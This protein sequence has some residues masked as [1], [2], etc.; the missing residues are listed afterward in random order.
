[1]TIVRFE[2]SNY[3]VEV[4]AGTRMVDVTDDHPKADVPFSCR[5]AN[6][7]TCRVEVKEG[8]SGFAPADDEELGVLDIFGDDEK[9]VRL[10]CQL[11]LVRDVP[12]VVLRVVEP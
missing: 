10:C 11:K 4:A 12:R 7:G 1:M 6:C 8:M 2:P 9:K 3:E 5:A